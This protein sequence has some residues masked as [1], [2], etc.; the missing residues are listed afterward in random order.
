[1]RARWIFA[2]LLVPA[3][4]SAAPTDCI[5]E[6]GQ[7]L[8][9][10]PILKSERIYVCSETGAFTWISNLEA[11]CGFGSIQSA[12]DIVSKINCFWDAANNCPGGTATEF[13]GWSSPGQ[14][15]YSY[16]CF[17]QLNTR[18]VNGHVLDPFAVM[19]RRTTRRDSMNMCTQVGNF[20]FS[21]IARI[22]KDL[23]CPT[24]WGQSTLPSGDL[25]CSRC[26]DNSTWNGNGCSCNSGYVK[27]PRTQ[28]CVPVQ[29][30]R[31][32]DCDDRDTC[33]GAERCNAGMCQRGTAP[34]CDDSKSCTLDRC[35]PAQNQCTNVLD[36]S[37]CTCPQSPP[38]QF[39]TSFQKD[40]GLTFDCPVVGG[41]I[42]TQI[43]VSACAMGQAAAC[44]NACTS[45]F[46]AELKGELKAN[47]CAATRSAAIT[48]KYDRKAQ[49]CI[50]CNPQTCQETCGPVAC[51]EAQGSVSGTVGFSQF[52]GLA[53]GTSWPLRFHWRC[54]GTVEGSI[55]PQYRYDDKSTGSTCINCPTACTRHGLA[56]QGSLGGKL[57]CELFVGASGSGNGSGAEAVGFLKVTG[58]GGGE[59]TSGACGSNTCEFLRGDLEAGARFKANLQLG[60][61]VVGLECV[62]K[63]S[64]CTERNSCGSCSCKNCVDSEI[65]ATCT[66]MKGGKW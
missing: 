20:G 55:G 64:G 46:S 26:P 45:K 11:S 12:G 6:G 22:A 13:P 36:K 25:K 43:S 9:T 66:V 34:T 23:S 7:M 10:E 31:D 28:Q 49:S 65:E 38:V 62:A 32:A 1:M 48:G 35:D 52:M 61:R 14:S 8:C 15:I 47:M 54:G 53:Q 3:F 19:T 16:N 59:F 29:C 37:L 39:G 57:G 5:S 2:A 63:Y 21:Y 56:L 17:G 33:N 60:W 50:D 40:I 51:S 58:T 30:Q 18:L 27:D 41:S 42:G 4:A 44:D 24:G